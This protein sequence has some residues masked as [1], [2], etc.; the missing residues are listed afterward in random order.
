MAERGRGLASVAAGAAA[1]TSPGLW[2]RALPGPENTTCQV[3]EKLVFVFNLMSR[4]QTFSAVGNGRD[5]KGR[6]SGWGAA[7]GSQQG[8]R[9]PA[10]DAFR[11]ESA[12][13]RQPATGLSRSPP[14]LSVKLST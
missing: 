11:D 13:P 8:S 10:P 7:G 5:P 6:S 4:A 9:S 14:T 3:G 1:V 2:A 12:F